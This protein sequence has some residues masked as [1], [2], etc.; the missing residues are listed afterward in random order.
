MSQPGCDVNIIVAVMYQVEAPEEAAFVH[1]KMYQPAAEIECQYTDDDGQQ[2]IGMKPVHQPE[3][4]IAAPVA[5]QN[6][7]YSQC[8]VNNKMYNGKTKIDRGMAELILFITQ[9]E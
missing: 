1:H 8:R 3:G 6:D 4:C 7:Q 5:K 9:R 2:H